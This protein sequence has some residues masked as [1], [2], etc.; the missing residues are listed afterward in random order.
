MSNLKIMV[1]QGINDE[2][3]ATA[4]PEVAAI[5]TLDKVTV[6]QFPCIFRKTEQFYTQ[7]WKLLKY[8]YCENLIPPCSITFLHVQN[9][10][11]YKNFMQ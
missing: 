1:R 4:I 3:N 5:E 9:N 7:Q 8:L 6:L 11:A 10:A 2:T